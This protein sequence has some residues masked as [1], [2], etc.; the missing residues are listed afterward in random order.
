MKNRSVFYN[1]SIKESIKGGKRERERERD[2]ED[3]SEGVTEIS[4]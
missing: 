1:N 4:N 3:G 2:I